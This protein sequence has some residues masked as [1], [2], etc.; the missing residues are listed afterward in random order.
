MR[1]Q[2]GG[3]ETLSSVK[4]RI[5]A[6][7]RVSDEEMSKWKFAVVSVRPPPEYLEDGDIVAE[8]LSRATQ[9]LGDWGKHMH[10]CIVITVFIA[11]NLTC[12]KGWVAMHACIT[13]SISIMTA[14]LD[15]NPTSGEGWVGGRDDDDDWVM[16]Q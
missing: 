16:P 7:L 4:A 14:C 8:K 10:A 3:E 2:V 6:K 12:R 11:L 1:V 5:Q 13:I 15:L 9:V